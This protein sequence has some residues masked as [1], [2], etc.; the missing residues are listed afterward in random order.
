MKKLLLIFLSATLIVLGSMF[1]PLW[2]C[3]FVGI[4]PALFALEGG[5]VKRWLWSGTLLW[6]IVSVEA[7]YWIFVVSHYFG[8]MGIVASALAV[9]GYAGLQCW[10]GLIGYGAF[11]WLRRYLTIRPS[12]LFAFSFGTAWHW[13]PVIFHGDLTL[14]IH[15]C[16]LFLQS[17]DLVGAYGLDCFLLFLGYELFIFLNTRRFSRWTAVALLLIV[18][19]IVYGALRTRQLRI[20]LQKAPVIRVAMIQPNI[21]SKEKRDPD[22]IPQ[23]LATLMRLTD[24]AVAE[25]HPALIVWPESM[26]P[27][28]FRYDRELQTILH[29]AVDRWNAD[30]YFGSDDFRREGD[31]TISYNGSFFLKA[32]TPGFSD[33]QKN[34]LLA[35]GEYLP[36]SDTFPVI[37]EWFP[38]NIGNFGRG[39]GPTK[40]EGRGYSFNPLICYESTQENY[41][42]RSAA[43]NAD[44]MVEITNDGWYL[45]TAALWYHKNLAVLRAIETRKSIVRVTNTGV[46][47]F[48]NPLGEESGVLPIQQASFSVVAVP[49]GGE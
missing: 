32:H 47:T 8:E 16:F 33:Y 30:L 41:V 39:K 13:V 5:S 42:R 24:Q 9:L 29:Q 1:K 44:F 12:L 31:R 38:P 40:L 6:F 14:L 46:T 10:P 43:L 3:G 26:F 27:L 49:R 34:V 7:C 25:H 21:E 28:S 48:I 45:D 18:A 35:F 4:V 19:N 36:L 17:L 2:I 37:R 20:T 22:F 15:G 11:A 23:S